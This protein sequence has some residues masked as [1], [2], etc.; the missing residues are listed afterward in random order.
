LVEG[1]IGEQGKMTAE[2]V[3]K[4]L[5]FGQM[6]LEQGWYDQAGEYFEQVLVARRVPASPEL[7]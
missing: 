6:A 7:A 3:D 1:K 4:L 5:T 2:Q